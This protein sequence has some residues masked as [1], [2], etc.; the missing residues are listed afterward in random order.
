MPRCGSG[1][2]TVISGRRLPRFR[3]AAWSGGLVAGVPRKGSL[4]FTPGLG[5]RAGRCFRLPAFREYC[6]LWFQSCGLSVHGCLPQS[7]TAV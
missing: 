7:A 6:S 4:Q 3:V 2:L 1:L 5:S